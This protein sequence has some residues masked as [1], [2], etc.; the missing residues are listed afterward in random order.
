MSPSRH[1]RLLS[2]LTRSALVCGIALY[3]ISPRGSLGDDALQLAAA[4]AKAE[5]EPAASLRLTFEHDVQPILTAAGCNAGACHGK[6]RGQN[7]FQLSLLGFDA[8]FDYAAIVQ[9]AQGRRVFPAA[10]QNSLLL[11][12]AAADMPHGGGRR[13]DPAGPLYAVVRRWIAAGMPRRAA[14]DPTLEGITLDRAEHVLVPGEQR[15]LRV[16]ARFSDGST[17]DVTGVTAFQSNEPAIVAV[18]E[19]GVIR[20]GDL[21]GEATVMARYMGEI[22]TCA[23]MIPLAGDVDRAIYDA[24]PRWNFIDELVWNKLAQLGITP[25][26][27][28]DDSTFLR[29]AY[30]DVIGRLPSAD[31]ARTFLADG[32]P[33]KRARLVDH[34]LERSEYADHWANKWVDLL[35]PNPYRVGIKATLSL[36]A[37]LRDAFRQNMPYDQMVRRLVTAEGSTWRNGAATLFRDRRQPDEIATMVSQLFLGV[38][39]ECAKCHHHPFEVWGQDDFYGLAAYFARVGRKGTGL[40]PPISGGEEIVLTVPSGTVK[41]GRTGEPV[42]PKPLFGQTPPCGPDEDPRDVLVD[43]MVAD[44]EGYFAQVAANRIWAAI[45][46]RGLVDPVDDLRATNPP[47]NAPLLEALAGELRRVEYDQK[48]LIRTIMAS[49]VYQLSSLPGERNSA[50][51]RNYSRHYRQ[52]LRAEVLLDAVCDVTGVP[53]SFDAMPPDARAVELWTTRIGSLFLDAFGRPDPNQD[54]PCER[55]ADSTVVQTLHMMNAPRIHEK[56]VSDSGRAAELATSE[57][58]PAEI[59]E[60]LY[61]AAYARYPTDDER[62]AIVPLFGEDSA[63]RRQATEDLMWAL[64]NTPEFLFKD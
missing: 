2:H 61:L 18:D 51:T 50:D 27:A 37:W 24:L 3:T 15:P 62:A 63:S 14:D 30:L 40:S 44:E 17:R 33:D 7:G 22:A 41:H 46:G 6:Q 5:V 38:R 45:M 35:R 49:Y 32:D 20:A 11:R 1:A 48:K 21:A 58:A 53:E 4:P 47:T 26:P 36:D 42:E 39:L 12:K 43:W 23:T 57:R 52:R 34:L 29:R 56:V 9:E 28:V 55:I 59:A 60:E 54:P 64:L 10:P 19:A 13:L 31:E 16:T 8:D 25:S